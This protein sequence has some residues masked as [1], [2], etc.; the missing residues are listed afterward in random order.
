MGISKL[1]QKVKEQQDRVGRKVLCL[2]NWLKSVTY[3]IR[4]NFTVGYLF[5][6]Q[7]KA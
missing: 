6:S 2:T 4:I 3:Q 1:R 5:L 7:L